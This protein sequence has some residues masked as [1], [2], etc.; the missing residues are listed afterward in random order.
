MNNFGIIIII[1]VITFNITK[2]HDLNHIFVFHF[3]KN[4]IFAACF[5]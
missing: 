5:L 3:K 1:E 4:I 2:L